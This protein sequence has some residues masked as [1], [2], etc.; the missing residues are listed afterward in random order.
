MIRKPS[1]MTGIPKKTI[2]LSWRMGD[3]S[4]DPP[5][6]LPRIE[7]MVNIRMKRMGATINSVTYISPKIF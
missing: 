2:R 5:K 1:A 6:E 3:R 4:I 7:R